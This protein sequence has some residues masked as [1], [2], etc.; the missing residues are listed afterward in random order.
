MNLDQ[1]LRALAG[2]P[3]FSPEQALEL[4]AEGF[5]LPDIARALRPLVESDD[6]DLWWWDLF[7]FECLVADRRGLEAARALVDALR[8]GSGDEFVAAYARRTVFAAVDSSSDYAALVRIAG[9]MGTALDPGP[10]VGVMLQR[11]ALAA[12]LR[13]PRLSAHH[14]CATSE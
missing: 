6:E 3:A 5:T 12:I 2:N 11:R 4:E 10:V 13:D 1:R 8:P 7:G 14:S 9:E